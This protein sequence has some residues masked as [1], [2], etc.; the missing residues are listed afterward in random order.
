MDT[1]LFNKRGYKMPYTC[2]NDH[3]LWPYD[4]SLSPLGFCFA[5]ADHQNGTQLPV[6]NAPLPTSQNHENVALSSGL[7]F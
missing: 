7:T 4:G 5:I 2:V 3:I 1:V 6:R